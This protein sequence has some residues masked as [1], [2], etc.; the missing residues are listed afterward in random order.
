M[1][2]KN[3][4]FKPSLKPSYSIEPTFVNATMDPSLEP[5]FEPT[6]EPS[7][8]PTIEPTIS[9]TTT[10]SI[11]NTLE[12]TI[13]VTISK[14]FDPTTPVTIPKT[15]E[16]TYEPTNIQSFEPSDSITFE[17]S[18]IVTTLKPSRNTTKI[19]DHEGTFNRIGAIFVGS[20]FGSVVCMMVLICIIRNIDKKKSNETVETPI[21]NPL[22]GNN[23]INMEQVNS[24][25]QAKIVKSNHSIKEEEPLN[26][27][28]IQNPL[29][30]D[31]VTIDIHGSELDESEF[32]D[33]QS[34]KNIEG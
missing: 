18:Q 11:S 2:S 9:L 29:Q 31:H 32:F 6:L 21:E 4:T 25:N 12:P 3:P 16:P 23:E 30:E 26:I 34:L 17:P 33:C 19:P 7:A 20:I 27:I 13:S 14:T 22:Q 1:P 5:S 10:P 8:Y 24:V 15:F 28:Q